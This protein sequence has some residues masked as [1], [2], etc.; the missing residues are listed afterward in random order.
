MAKGLNIYVSDFFE[1]NKVHCDNSTVADKL[2]SKII[3]LPYSQ[4]EKIYDI[5]VKIIDFNEH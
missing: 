5:L 1:D 4:Q 3:S 2:Y